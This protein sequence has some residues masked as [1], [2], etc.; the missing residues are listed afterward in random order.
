MQ[1]VVARLAEQQRDVAVVPAVVD[2]GGGGERRGTEAV[3]LRQSAGGRRCVALRVHTRCIACW[4]ESLD[5]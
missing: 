1:L 2:R 5:P 3:R 4:A